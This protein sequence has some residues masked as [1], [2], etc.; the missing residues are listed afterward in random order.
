MNGLSLEGRV[1]L[2]TGAASGI[3]FAVARL[4][5]LQG[6]RIGLLDV[7]QERV[8]EAGER[9]RA[10][11]IEVEDL[12]ADVSKADQIEAATEQLARRFGRIDIVHANAGINGVWA[13]I[14]DISPEEFDETIAVNLR[15]S[16]LTIK[17]AVPFL[18]RQ[19]GVILLTSSVNGTRIF[20]N[21][22]ATP[23]SCSKAAQVAM[24]K[25]LAVELGGAG[26]RV[27]AICPGYFPSNIHETTK[28]K[29][30]KPIRAKAHYPDGAR[31]LK[32]ESMPEQ[33]GELALFLVSDMA[34]HIT[35]EVVYIDAGVSLVIG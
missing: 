18:K 17:F 3:G 1:A 33:V 22:G 21:S 27:N 34:K 6:A 28:R 2:I 24:A 30:D 11:G 25:M 23:Y 4:L 13:R 19:G 9:L 8:T 16:F 35:G 15:G 20:S 29:S 26:I 14:E 5:G 10:E 32:S 7:V 31:P 12:V